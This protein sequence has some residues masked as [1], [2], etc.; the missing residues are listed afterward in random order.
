[1]C[2]SPRTPFLV[3]RSAD[4][5]AIYPKHLEWATLLSNRNDISL[6]SQNMRLE[7]GKSERVPPVNDVQWVILGFDMDMAPNT[8]N[9]LAQPA[10]LKIS[11][12]AVDGSMDD[13]MVI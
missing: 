4:L 8:P 2:S 6:S 10:G 3:D 1:M 12:Y 9:T 13:S 7:T 11:N 5:K